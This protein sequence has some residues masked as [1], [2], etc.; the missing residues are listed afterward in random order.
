MESTP[1]LSNRE[2]LALIIDKHQREQIA[3]D[4]EECAAS[5]G[6]FIQ[7]AWHVLEPDQRYVHGF[8][9]DAITEHLD[10][11]TRGEI[12]RLLVNVP[13]GTMKS[14]SG[15]VFW[16]AWEWGPKGMPSIR[17][18][19][20]SH[21]ETLAIRDSVKMRRLVQSEWYQRRWPT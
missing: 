11:I 7:R 19:G 21:E 18:I 6:T 17:F 8:H 9:M 2:R 12:I 5:L 10:A 15:A 3:R 14:M 1:T 4:R 20:A 16:P 13:P